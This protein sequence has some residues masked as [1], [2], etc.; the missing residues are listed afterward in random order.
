LAA[1]ALATAVAGSRRAA[2]E[3][4]VVAAAARLSHFV[5]L[6]MKCFFCVFS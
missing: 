3:R 5:L 6:P 4:P 2:V 1:A